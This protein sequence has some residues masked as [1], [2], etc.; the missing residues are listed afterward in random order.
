[1]SDSPIDTKL[2]LLMSDSPIYINLIRLMCDSS[3]DTNLNRS[4]PGIVA[5]H[6]A[7]QL[8]FVFIMTHYKNRMWV[9]HPSVTIRCVE[10]IWHL[11]LFVL[12]NLAFNLGGSAWLPYRIG[13][14]N[15][16]SD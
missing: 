9:I 14:S 8:M 11:S 2:M 1:V 5:L 16:F 3:M 10:Y 6:D 15:S 4:V 7:F 12:T 13:I